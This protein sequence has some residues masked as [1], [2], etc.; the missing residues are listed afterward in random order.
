ML[1]I[2]VNVDGG[3]YDYDDDDYDGDGDEISDFTRRPSTDQ[4]VIISSLRLFPL[5]ALFHRAATYNLG[6]VK[7]NNVVI[8]AS[9]LWPQSLIGQ[10]TSLAILLVVVVVVLKP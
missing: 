5:L 6:P 9:Q 10:P 2:D 7:N 8:Y 4:H 3:D 1:I